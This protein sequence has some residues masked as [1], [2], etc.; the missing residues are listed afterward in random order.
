M[1]AAILSFTSS[2]L[3]KRFE[4][5][6]D[7]LKEI[8]GDFIVT[9]ISSVKERIANHGQAL[10][11]DRYVSSHPIAGSGKIIVYDL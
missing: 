11:G 5:P 4:T 2:W 3:N 6:S 7:E 10:F 1:K 8:G 9:D